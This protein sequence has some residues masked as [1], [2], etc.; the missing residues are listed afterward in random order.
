MPF[1]L[2]A[3]I[4]VTD[5]VMRKGLRVNGKVTFSACF[6]KRITCQFYVVKRLIGNN[7]SNLFSRRLYFFTLLAMHI[8]QFVCHKT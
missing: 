1:I 8:F 7:R 2:Q 4:V 5:T 3:Q 6:G